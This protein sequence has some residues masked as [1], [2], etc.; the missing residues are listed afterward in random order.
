MTEVI[1]EKQPSVIEKQEEEYEEVITETTE[2]VSAPTAAP[3]A[4]NT[5]FSLFGS[6]SS[7]GSGISIGIFSYLVLIILGGIIFWVGSSWSECIQCLPEQ[8]RRDH[9]LFL[10]CIRCWPG[11]W[12]HRILGSKSCVFLFNENT[13]TVAVIVVDHCLIPQCILYK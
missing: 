10:Q 6:S 2:T 3:S 13:S 8:G 11:H 12:H 5:G 7:S 4:P 1:V 9:Q